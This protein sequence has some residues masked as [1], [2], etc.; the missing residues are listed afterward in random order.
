MGGTGSR[1]E[2]YHAKKPTIE[3]C[4]IISFSEVL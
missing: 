2:T 3:Q 4:W 1:R